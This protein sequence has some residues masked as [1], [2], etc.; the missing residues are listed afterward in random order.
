MNIIKVTTINADGSI[1]FEGFYGPEEVQFILEVGT[2]Y[3]LH[4]GTERL[5]EDE[6][7]EEEEDDDTDSIRVDGT[8]TMQ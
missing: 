4:Q 6:G 2:N 8:D 1:A 7:E 5:M 3:L